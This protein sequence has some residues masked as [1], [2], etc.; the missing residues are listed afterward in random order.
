MDAG[1]S[2]CIGALAAPRAGVSFFFNF[3]TFARGEQMPQ[4]AAFGA[5]KADRTAPRVNPDATTPRKD[6]PLK[7][8]HNPVSLVI[9]L[10][11]FKFSHS[12]AKLPN[13]AVR[14]Y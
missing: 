10:R 8:F 6:C 9:Y 14:F 4:G 12:T 3:T 11:F 7:N 13:R 2:I 5:I 1:F